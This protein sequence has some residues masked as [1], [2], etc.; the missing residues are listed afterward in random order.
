MF[1]TISDTVLFIQSGYKISE[2]LPELK[3]FFKVE[4]GP[5]FK[6]SMK[7]SQSVDTVILFRL[8]KRKDVSSD[9]PCTTSQSIFAMAKDKFSKQNREQ[10]YQEIIDE[11]QG[12]STAWEE[13]PPKKHKSQ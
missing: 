9:L 2:R 11:Y 13:P 7:V 10:T 6:L 12:S 3:R 4:E 1:N 8:T 5:R